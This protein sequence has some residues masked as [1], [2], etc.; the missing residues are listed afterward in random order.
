VP[1]S[2]HANWAGQNFFSILSMSKSMKAVRLHE[3]GSAAVLRYEDAQQPTAGPGEVLMKVVAAGVNPLDWK[4][5]EG[6]LQGM[7]QLTLPFI[8]GVDLAGTVAALGEGVTDWAVG[9]AV[10]GTVQVNHNGAYAEYVTAPT[11]SLAPKP[12]GLTF[13]EAAALP[14]AV[15]TAWNALTVAGFEAG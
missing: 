8:L 9:D 7:L 5:R 11:T 1:E 15:L 3:Y 6:Y 4:T 10:Y 12:A 2:I 13:A 14:V